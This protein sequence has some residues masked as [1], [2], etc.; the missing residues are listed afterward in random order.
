MTTVWFDG[1]CDSLL[2]KVQLWYGNYERGKVR[3][4]R[5]FLDLDG[6][7]KDVPT[8]YLHEIGLTQKE[9]EY[10]VR[11][12]HATRPK[13]PITEM[14][15]ALPRVLRRYRM[16]V[17]KEYL[18]PFA[19]YKPEVREILRALEEAQAAAKGTKTPQRVDTFIEQ[20]K[21]QGGHL[22]D[23]SGKN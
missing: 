10:L 9:A 4:T 15:S 6:V 13:L 22:W 21:K 20:K 2:R 7:L 16:T 18:V 5:Q 23:M 8:K 19:Y 3:G 14:L 11:I 1:V 17:A 12:M